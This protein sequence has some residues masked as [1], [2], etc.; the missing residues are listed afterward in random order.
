MIINALTSERCWFS[1]LS[2]VLRGFR[3]SID[4]GNGETI[5]VISLA[6][7]RCNCGDSLGSWGRSWRNCLLELRRLLQAIAATT[8]ADSS[9]LRKNGIL[10]SDLPEKS[11]EIVFVDFEWPRDIKHDVDTDLSE[12]GRINANSYREIN[13]SPFV[14][15]TDT[16]SNKISRRVRVTAT[17]LKL[18]PMFTYG[19][20]TGTSWGR[21]KFHYF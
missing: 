15:C 20:F 2:C 12:P 9:P 21:L 10:R 18:Q 7:T 5:L 17:R 14:V 19:F 16:N 11:C 1:L 6:V 3:K 4:D 13:L 8:N